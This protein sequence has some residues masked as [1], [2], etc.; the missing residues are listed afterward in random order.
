MGGGGAGGAILLKGETVSM[1]INLAVSDR[2][3]GNTQSNDG[4]EGNRIEDVARHQANAWVQYRFLGGPVAGLR[5]AGG[6]T[7]VGDRPGE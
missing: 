1:G 4:D 3:L 7:H 5:L 2:G 6:V